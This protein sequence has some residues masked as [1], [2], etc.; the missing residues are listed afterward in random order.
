MGEGEG[1]GL[2]GFVTLSSNLNNLSN[3]FQGF[4][5]CFSLSTI[6]YFPVRL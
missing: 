1:R 3:S 6:P 4:K 2:K 5:G